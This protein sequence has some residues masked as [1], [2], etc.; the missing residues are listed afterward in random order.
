MADHADKNIRENALS[1]MGELYKLLNEDIW[2][3]IGNVT[4]KVQGLLEARFKKISGKE[5]EPVVTRHT[6]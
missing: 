2:R 3:A 4:T 5:D 6:E 1:A